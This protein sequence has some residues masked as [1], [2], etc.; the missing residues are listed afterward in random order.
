MLA[1]ATAAQE[2]DVAVRPP[3]GALPLT[4][5]LHLFDAAAAAAPR[6]GAGAAFNVSV[7]AA[8]RT[9]RV[10]NGV[11]EV[12]EFRT[13]PGVTPLPKAVPT[14]CVQTSL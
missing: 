11:C 14:P 2:A 3:Y 6:T 8:S 7:T 10:G 4:R 12:G 1:N 13:S 9:G 5:V